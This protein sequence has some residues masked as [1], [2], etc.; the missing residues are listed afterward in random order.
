VFEPCYLETHRSGALTEKIATAREML[1]SCEVCPRRCKVNRLEGETGFCKTGEL[2]VISSSNPHF[3][4]ED[5]LVGTHGSGTIFMTHCNLMCVFCQNYDISHLGHGREITLPE[6]AKL[7]IRL[8]KMGCHNI[9]FVTPS[10]VVP[11]ILEALPYA[12]EGGLRIPLV[13]N[14][15]GY[16]SVETI[17]LLDGIFDIYMPDFKFADDEVSWRYCKVKDYFQ[18]A[19]AAITE[20]HRQ[21]GDLAA[22]DEGIAEKGLLIRHLIMPE[23][24]AGTREIMR[25]L[26]REISENTYVNIMAQYRPCG[27]TTR[28]P[29]INRA[30]TNRE[31]QEAIK[32]AAEE[33]ITR[34]DERRRIRILRWLL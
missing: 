10:H 28:Y 18:V 24:R 4:E 8:Q 32:I 23:G 16:D 29:E 14:T 20:M 3:G 30:P 21:V 7:M 34:L 22:N 25:F 33:G 26:A 2:P 17:R 5:P 9:N 11:Q 13:Y 31:H 27:E 6:F 19:K 1:T 12:I 15:G